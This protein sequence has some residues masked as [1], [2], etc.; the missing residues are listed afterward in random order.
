MKNSIIVFFFLLVV[1]CK[2][3]ELPKESASK[4]DSVPVVDSSASSFYKIN[5]IRTK[6]TQND[7]FKVW[8]Y[9]FYANY[10]FQ[11]LKN[12]STINLE[13]TFEDTDSLVYFSD[14]RNEFGE[15]HKKG[16][17]FI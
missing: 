7:T 14:D 1:S 5:E 6:I 16:E 13:F 9:E 11:G 15:L 2:N 3:E 12:L 8:P 4:R 17:N 10:T